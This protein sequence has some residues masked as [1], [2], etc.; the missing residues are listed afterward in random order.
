[1]KPYKPFGSTLSDYLR[2]LKTCVNTSSA[3][4]LQYMDVKELSERME[5]ARTSAQF[6]ILCYKYDHTRSKNNLQE[7]QSAI[8]AYRICKEKYYRSYNRYMAQCEKNNSQFY[9]RYK[10]ANLNF[11]SSDE[12]ATS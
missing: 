2:K 1:M 11:Q 5:Q 9:T 6:A 3:Q 10:P 8:E 12:K 4:P 7:M